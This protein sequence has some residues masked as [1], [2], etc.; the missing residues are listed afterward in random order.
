MDKF[1]YKVESNEE[2][3]TFLAFLNEIGLYTMYETE[4][5]LYRIV[6]PRG[7]FGGTQDP[8]NM[9]KSSLFSGGNIP[10]EA[11]SWGNK[12]KGKKT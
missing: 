9:D 7:E 6:T 10:I 11:Y 3:D 5:F 1:Y 8:F 12:M 4:G 2:G